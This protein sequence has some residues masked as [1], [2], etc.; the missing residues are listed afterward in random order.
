MV[1]SGASAITVDAL[2]LQAQSLHR[3]AGHGLGRHDHAHRALHGELAQAQAHP[4]AQVL[5]CALERREVVQGDDH[6]AGT[7]QDRALHPRRVK[8]LGAPRPVGLDDLDALGAGLAQRGQQRAR[9]ASDAAHVG[10]RPAV[11]GDPA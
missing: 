5:A 1:G 11:E 10:G 9:V 2:A 4:R 6:R 7:A 3:V 8:D